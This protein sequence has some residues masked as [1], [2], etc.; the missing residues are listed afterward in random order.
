MMLGLPPG[1][2]RLKKLWQDPFPRLDDFKLLFPGATSR[3]EK[4]NGE[5]RV[6]TILGPNKN[7]GSQ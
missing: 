4:P 5:F 2:G 3:Q 1:Q 6:A 7:F